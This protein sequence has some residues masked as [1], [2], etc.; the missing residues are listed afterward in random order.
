MRKSSRILLV[1]SLILAGPA[2]VAHAD[3]LLMQG[4]Q[5]AQA[6]AQE[7]PGRGMSMQAVVAQWGEPTTRQAAVGQPPITRWDYRDFVV[8]FEYSHVID[9]VP[10]RH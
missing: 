4:I 2:G 6:T 1:A 7:R 9:A 3:T 5:Q 10:R 8:F